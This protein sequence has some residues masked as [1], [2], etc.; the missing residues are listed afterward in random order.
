LTYGLFSETSF[1]GCKFADCD[2]SGALLSQCVI[3]RTE[4]KDVKLVGAELFHAG[5]RG[6][7]LSECDISGIILSRELSEV[8]GVAVNFE[9]AAELAGLLGLIVK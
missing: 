6:L 5:I 3:K 2:M 8:R 7:D 1:D 9:Q 4:M